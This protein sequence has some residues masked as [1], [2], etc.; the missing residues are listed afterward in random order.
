MYDYSKKL[1]KFYGDEVA[2]DSSARSQL[3]EH[4]RTNEGRLKDGLAENNGPKVSRFQIQ[5]GYAMHTVVQ[6]PKNDYDI[7]NGVIFAAGDLVGPKGADISALD[8]RK[9]VRD[10]VDDGAFKTPPVVKPNCVRVFYEKGHHVDLPVYREKQGLLGNKYLEIASADWK[11]SDPAGVN[12][13]F[14]NQVGRSPDKDNDRQ[15][16]RI[17]TYLKALG[18]SRD[19]WNAPSGFMFSILVSEC[20]VSDARDDISL[21]KTLRKIEARLKTNLKVKHPVVD[22]YVTDGDDDPR[23]RFF[24][25]KV[26]DLLSDLAVLDSSD[27]DEAKAASAW[28]KFF[29]TEY[30]T[31]RVKEAASAIGLTSIVTSS[32]PIRTIRDG[33]RRYG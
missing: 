21:I 3:R 26:G 22:E 14:E 16:R 32:S 15:F 33:E 17:V 27:C 8:A 7:D 23:T 19:S 29:R 25:D 12:A 6:H 11:R 13:W 9:M 18:K 2:I 10:A 31:K 4:R 24:R 5:G 20:Y 1:L 30:F 28:D